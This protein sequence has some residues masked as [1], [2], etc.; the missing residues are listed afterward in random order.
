MSDETPRSLLG[1]ICIL[2]IHAL[3]EMKEKSENAKGF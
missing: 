1:L 2:V 3:R